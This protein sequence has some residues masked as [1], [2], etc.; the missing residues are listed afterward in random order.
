MIELIPHWS[1]WG[2]GIAAGT[3]R[4]SSFDP[5]SPKGLRI[6]LTLGPYSL[7]INF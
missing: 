7:H 5:A 6:V 3:Y 1:H 2:I 4:I